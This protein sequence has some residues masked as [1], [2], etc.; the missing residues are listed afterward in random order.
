MSEARHFRIEQ[1]D[2]AQARETLLAIRF[3]VF[4]DEQGVPAELE[5]DADDPQALHVLAWDATGR[6][7]LATARLLPNGH[8][9]RMAVRKDWRGQGIG[10]A[11][12]ER[13]TAL[14]LQAGL[15]SVLLNAQCSAEGFYRRHGFQ[16]EGDIFEDAGIAHRRMS[17]PLA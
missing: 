10:S 1:A 17:C 2:W 5:E 16:P 9:G 13:L 6:T 3:E 7:P 15:K 11:M 12:L 4:V 14:A 8:I